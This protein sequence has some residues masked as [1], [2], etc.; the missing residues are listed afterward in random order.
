MVSDVFGKAV[1]NLYRGGPANVSWEQALDGLS[2]PQALEVPAGLPH[3]VARVVAHVQFWQD[4]LL[5]T[6]AGESPTAPPHA[7]G[8]WPE[9]GEWESLKTAFVRDSG[10]LRDLTRDEAF[11]Q[12]LDP[13]GR[14]YGVALTNFAGHSLYHLGQVVTIRQALGFWLPPGGGDNW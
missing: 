2:A 9:P 14:P 6:V 13:Q 1:G 10:A 4:H 7:A 5:R 3:S 12:T 11:V 8:G